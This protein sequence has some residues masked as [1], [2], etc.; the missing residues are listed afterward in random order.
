MPPAIV[1]AIEG[2]QAAIKAAPQV[3]ALVEAGK[4]FVTE[5]FESGL[6]DKATQ[7]AQHKEMDD[8]MNA[9]NAGDVPAAW[10]QQPEA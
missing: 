2:I 10:Q 6:I 4:N 3:I 8:L 7:D 9:W 5:L 1:L